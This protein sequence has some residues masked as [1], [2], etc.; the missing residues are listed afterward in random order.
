MALLVAL[1]FGHHLDEAVADT[2]AWLRVF[3]RK[4]FTRR[5]SWRSGDAW[6]LGPEGITLWP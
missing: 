4:P 3:L 2:M 5:V 1:I 6:A